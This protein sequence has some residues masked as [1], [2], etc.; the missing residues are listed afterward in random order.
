MVAATTATA[1]PMMN[2][3]IQWPLA[4]LTSFREG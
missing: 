2:S 1:I 3:L 4:K